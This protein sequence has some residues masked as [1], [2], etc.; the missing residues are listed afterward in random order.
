MARHLA[1]RDHT[2]GVTPGAAIV[3]NHIWRSRASYQFTR[4]LSVRAIADYSAV[5]PD[6]DL[7]DLEREKRFTSDVLLTY[8]I[9]PWTALYAGYTDAYGNLEIDPFSRDRLRPTDSVFHST[10]RQ[11]F[12]KMSYLL[13]F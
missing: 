11:V 4:R 1:G 8:L 2:P 6:R 9:N 10:G 12:V 7:I 13:R 3:S 5:L